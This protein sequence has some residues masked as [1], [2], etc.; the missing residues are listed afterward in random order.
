M[1][2][3]GEDN[4]HVISS[5][6]YLSHIAEQEVS[7]PKH[8]PADALTQGKKVIVLGGGDTAMDCLR[9]ALRLGASEA[10]CVCRKPESGLRAAKREVNYAKEEGAKFIFESTASELVFKDGQLV[11]L[12]MN[13]PDGQ[14]QLEAD[15]IVVAYGSKP[16]KAKWL[17]EVGISFGSNDAVLTGIGNYQCQTTNDKIFAG[18][19]AVRGSNLVVNAVKD[20]KAAAKSIMEFLTDIGRIGQKAQKGQKQKK[21]NGK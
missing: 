18:G 14:K 3:P 15:L 12:V 21:Q 20:G 9:S 5:A 10:I 13:N 7:D 16:I 8:S 17:E 1:N 4:E 6:L 19:D 11:V 2:L